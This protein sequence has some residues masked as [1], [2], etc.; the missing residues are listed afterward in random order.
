MRDAACQPVVYPA[1][2][3]MFVSTESG[4]PVSEG[5]LGYW[6]DR[7]KFSPADCGT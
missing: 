7:W 3:D 6:R 2:K 5:E 4:V 1:R